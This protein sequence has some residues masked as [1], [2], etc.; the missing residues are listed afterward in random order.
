[1][2]VQKR[3]SNERPR[4]LRRRVVIPARLRSGAEWSDACILNISS[5]GLLIHAGRAGP[6]GTL[7]ELHR[8][9]HVI[10]ARVM[11]RDGTKV[12]VRCDERLPVDE[13]MSLAHSTSLRLIASDG[14]AVE[15][16]R[17]PRADHSINRLR[18]RALEFIGIGAIVTCLAVGAGTLVHEAFAS[19][20]ARVEAALSGQS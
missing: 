8:G 19:P 13:I 14:A 9:D 11:W 5:R 10:I 12:G 3:K 1:M 17:H 15:R 6:E 7:V 2:A 20:V 16:R 4:E 18:A